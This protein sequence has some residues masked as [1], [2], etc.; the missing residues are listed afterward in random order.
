MRGLTS[1]AAPTAVLAVAALAACGTAGLAE[2]GESWMRAGHDGP[3]VQ[4]RGAPSRSDLTLRA[5][6]DGPARETPETVFVA[7]WFRGRWTCAPCPPE[8]SCQPCIGM[9]RFSDTPDAPEADIFLLHN[10]GEDEDLEEGAAYTLQLDLRDRY[11]EHLRVRENNPLYFDG[12][13]DV[14]IMAIS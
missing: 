12:V 13:P 8:F 14:R 10:F 4:E 9:L 5:L 7:A 2:P 1:L 3:G 11:R 6:R